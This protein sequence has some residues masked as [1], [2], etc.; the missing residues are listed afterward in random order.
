[1]SA[2]IS[3][4]TR[5]AG[6]AAAVDGVSEQH[7]GPGRALGADVDRRDEVERIVLETPA[8]LTTGTG[9]LCPQRREHPPRDPPA[10]V[11][12]RFSAQRPGLHRVCAAKL[13]LFFL[14]PQGLN[15]VNAVG[16]RG[17]LPRRAGVP[18][19]RCLTLSG[20]SS[21]ARHAAARPVHLPGRQRKRSPRGAAPDGARQPGCI[22]RV[23]VSAVTGTRRCRNPWCRGVLVP[24]HSPCH[25]ESPRVQHARRWATS[26]RSSPSSPTTSCSATSGSG[27]SCRSATAA[28]SPARRSSRPA[29][30]SR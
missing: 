1:M 9:V 5:G 10:R 29:R 8:R 12:P 11:S 28:S 15:R 7:D 3:P 16:E 26:R 20:G 4:V 25:P 14:G 19:G 27:P 23:A 6:A 21:V 17:D 18:P 24:S 13:R 30:R 2:G 22:T